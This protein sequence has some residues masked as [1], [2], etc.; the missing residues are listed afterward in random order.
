MLQVKARAKINWTLDIVGIR[1][2]GYHLMDMLMQTV[3][4]HDRLTIEKGAALS[5]RVLSKGSPLG[6]GA[7]DA[8]YK[9]GAGGGARESSAPVPS[10]G[11]NLVLKAARALQQETGC[12][13]GATLQLEKRIPV[14]A[15][16][17]GGSAD[18]AAALVGLNQLWGTGLSRE[19]LLPIGLA[20]GAD[21]PFLLTGGLA[22][23]QGIG[24]CIAP[25]YPPPVLWLV[26]VQPCRGLS[27][28]EI[29]RGYDAMAAPQIRRP[30]TEAAQRALMAG[31]AAAL[32]RSMGNV[33][34][35][36]SIRYRPQI[37]QCAQA[38]QEVGALGAMMTGSGAAVYGVFSNEAEAHKA[39]G[40]LYKRYPQVYVTRSCGLGVEVETGR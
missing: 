19:Q 17:G 3:E 11:E 40:L 22:R 20:I 34:E 15:G 6:E 28:P 23:V 37:A 33:L 14:G 16:M 36:V 2:D 1:Q 29:F 35:P 13:Q 26:V 21:V 12:Q 9:Q 31:D 32:T 39:A 7:L 10:G 8:G 38:L 4:L 30:H 25:L 18:A 27:T 24:D 5:L